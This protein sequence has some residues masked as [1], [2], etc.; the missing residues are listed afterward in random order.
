[1]RTQSTDTHPKAE[2][3]QIEL[4]RKASPSKR[5]ALMR[6]LSE[7]TISLAKRAIR[8]ANPDASEQELNLIFVEI[9]YG[10]ELAQRLRA[11]LEGRAS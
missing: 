8:R 7:Q 9:H 6:R 1:M 11:Y 5:F 10:R 4:L 2:A 3:V